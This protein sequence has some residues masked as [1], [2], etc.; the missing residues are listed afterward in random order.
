MPKKMPQT[1]IDAPT[2]IAEPA[3]AYRTA[4]SEISSTKEWN[5]NVPFQGTQKEWWEYF[6]S[7][8]KSRFYPVSETHQRISQCLDKKR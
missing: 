8:E 2:I 5:P 6:H 3:A 7:I 4:V 1:P